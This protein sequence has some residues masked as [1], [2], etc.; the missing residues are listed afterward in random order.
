MTL[1]LQ[2]ECDSTKLF[3]YLF[4]SMNHIPAV[5]LLAVAEDPL[6]VFVWSDDPPQAYR[7]AHTVH[8]KQ[9]HYLDEKREAS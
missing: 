5:I 2:I 1:S 7:E 3:I 6:T 8:I 9:T 4:I